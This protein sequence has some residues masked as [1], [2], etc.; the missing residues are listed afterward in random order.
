MNDWLLSVS[1]DKSG[2]KYAG[3]TLVP[4]IDRD[5]RL[6]LVQGLLS[7]SLISYILIKSNKRRLSV[8]QC[9]E[10]VVFN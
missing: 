3:T 8:E 10:C 9:W 1:V 2:N 7:I 6:L 5:T 4:L